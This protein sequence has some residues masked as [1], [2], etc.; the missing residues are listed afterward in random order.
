MLIPAPLSSR[1]F[2][3]DS[4][5]FPMIPP[6]S[7]PCISSLIVRVTSNPPSITPVSMSSSYRELDFWVVKSLV[8]GGSECQNW[9]REST[10]GFIFLSSCTRTWTQGTA[11]T[12]PLNHVS[13]FYSLF[14]FPHCYWET[15]LGLLPWDNKFNNKQ[16]LMFLS[17]YLNL[18][19]VS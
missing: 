13:N 6:T 15:N 10:Q 16:G 9:R 14:L 17:V 3:T 12:S 11:H 4:P 1:I 18:S 8:T 2:L 5:F 7:F 19:F